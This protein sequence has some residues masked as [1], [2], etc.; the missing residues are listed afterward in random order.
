MESL[1]EQRDQLQVSAK[2]WAEEYERMQRQY[3][4]KLNELNAEIEDLEDFRQ[5][6]QR[7][8][9]SHEN[10]KLRQSLFDEW[11]DALMESFGPGIYRGEVYERPIFHH[12]PQNST[13][14]GV[15][16]ELNSYF[17][18][19]NQPGLILRSVE[20]AVAHL[21]VED[22]RKLTSGTG[23]F[24]ARMYILSVFY[25]LASLEEINCVEFDIEEGDH[26]GP[27][28]YCRDSADS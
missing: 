5:R 20:N 6:Y 13:P 7:L 18:E 21:E 9:S 15:V 19:S 1:K 8:S 12:R 16:E 4:D 22:D 28:R 2:Q 26:A 17:Q 27:D 23:S 25:S 10:L 14:E 3:L 24:G 11:A